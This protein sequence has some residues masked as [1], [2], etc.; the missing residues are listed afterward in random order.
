MIDT[1]KILLESH[2][3]GN[4]KLILNT[5]ITVTEIFYEKNLF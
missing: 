4:D 5:F 3:F 2:S 1:L